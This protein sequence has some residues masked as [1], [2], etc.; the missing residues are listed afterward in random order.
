MTVREIVDVMNNHPINNRNRVFTN[1][2]M[3]NIL[4]N[5]SRKKYRLLIKGRKR[6]KTINRIL[7]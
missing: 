3:G 5:I 7:M 6:D 4:K 2:S 1:K